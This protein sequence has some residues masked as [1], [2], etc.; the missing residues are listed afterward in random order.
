MWTSTKDLVPELSFAGTW[1]IGT[2]STVVRVFGAVTSL[3]GVG[4]LGVGASLADVW[5]IGAAK[6][7]AGSWSEVIRMFTTECKRPTAAS[8]GFANQLIN[9]QFNTDRNTKDGSLQ[10]ATTPEGKP[11]IWF[12]CVHRRQQNSKGPHKSNI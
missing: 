12:N 1:E 10:R 8:R 2:S 11:E 7:L 5:R 9:F 4:D 6:S 3:A